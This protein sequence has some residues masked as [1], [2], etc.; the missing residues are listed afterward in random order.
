MK[1]LIGVD[2]AIKHGE[3]FLGEYIFD[4]SISDRKV[5]Q[6]ADFIR[7][8]HY[9]GELCDIPAKIF[10]E[11]FYQAQDEAIGVIQDENFPHELEE[12]NF[13]LPRLL[14]LGI[15]AL[16]PDDVKEKLDLQQFVEFHEVNSV[17][18][19]WEIE[20]Y[21]PIVEEPKKK[22]KG[23][24][25]LAI[26]QPWA[27]LIACGVKDIE[28]R[29]AMPTKCR[30][31]F[32]AASS[33]KVPWNELPPFVQDTIQKLEAANILPPYEQLPS[34][35][36]I[37]H[38]DI[39]DVTYDQVESIWGRDWDGIKY[40]LRNAQVL[41]EPLYGLNKATPYFYNVEGYDDEHLPASHVVDLSGIE[42]PK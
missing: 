29:D 31:I 38:V 24:K 27:S 10:D 42:L 13:V 25:T 12:M 14:P 36:I 32:V 3:E 23:M 37:G 34:K 18:E 35:C 1:Y 20:D 22:A 33:T 5:K 21:K 11:I 41:D 2:F 8:G 15:L 4:Y 19:L 40:V 7:E 16:L 28:C 6:I 30:K 17:D 39:V 26:R 9:T